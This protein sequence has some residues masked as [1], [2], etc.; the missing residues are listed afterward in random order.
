MLFS[1]HYFPELHSQSP[2]QIR[3]RFG[4]KLLGLYEAYQLGIAIPSTSMISTQEY[5]TFLE[6]NPSEDPKKFQFA[7]IPFIQK[8]LGPAL[9]ALDN[10]LY[11]VR[12]SCQVEDSAKHSFAGIFET[13]LNVPKD[14]L[15]EAIAFVWSSPLQ[16]RARNYSQALS[17]MGVVIQPMIQAKYTGICFTKHP[18]PSTLF[19]NPW[20]VVEFAPASGDRIVQGEIIPCRLSGTAD[21]LSATLENSWIN[22]LLKAIFEIKKRYHHEADIEFAID[23]NDNFWLLQQRPISKIIPS[24]TLDLSDYKRLYKRS[25]LA[26]DVELLIDGCS[27]FLAPYLEIPLC[28]ERWM[29]MTTQDVQELWVDEILNETIL[30]LVIGKIEKDPSYLPRLKM[31]YTDHDQRLKSPG[32]HQLFQWFEWITPFTAHYYAPIFLIDA[33]YTSLLREIRSIDSENAEKDLF[34]L[35]TAG[36]SSLIDLLNQELCALKHCSY[37]E[38]LPKLKELA[39]RFGFMKCRQVFE[40]PYTPRELFEMIKHVPH[41]TSSMNN[42]DFEAKKR[43]YLRQ[44]HQI[45]RLNYLR[46][47]I[48]V[49]NQEMEYLLFAF[50][51]ARPLIDDVCSSLSIDGE[52]FWRS[53][54]ES[55]LRALETHTPLAPTPV[56]HLSIIQRQGQPYLSD[57]IEIRFPNAHQL[58]DLRGRTVY[59]KGILE[60]TVYIAFTPETFRD[61]PQRPCVLVTGMTTPDFVPF[62]RNYFDALITDEGGILCHAAIIAREIPIACIVGTGIS[63]T[64]L[65]QGERIRIDFDRGEIEKLDRS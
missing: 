48:R 9:D 53:S 37:E 15:A 55:L 44:E 1:L 8:R 43:K 41:Q 18:S 59:G 13:K 62:I 27:R 60:A 11:A 32:P 30:S 20:I 25:L 52:T 17:L 39:H 51:A 35:G 19:E 61:P 4:G 26:L 31:R 56:N 22:D 3:H 29:V 14:N 63:T 5:K 12:S 65:T 38:C 34:E 2:Q 21:V 49:R 54:K 24:C 58:A 64:V 57:Q 47:W 50:L 28:L 45:Q 36:I 6:T 16:E 10:G 42:A 46:E 7:A 23:A 33:L 40:D